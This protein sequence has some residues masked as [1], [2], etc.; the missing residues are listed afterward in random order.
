MVTNIDR[1]HLDY[2]DGIEAILRAFATFANHVP[3]YGVSVMCADDPQVRE[4]LP[5]ITKRTVLYGTSPDAEVRADHIELLPRGSHSTV[6]VG[7]RNLGTL[8]LRVPGR[9]NVLNALAAVAVG[10]ECEVVFSHIAE[11]LA[12]FTGVSRRFEIRGDVSGVTV[13][14]DYGHHPTEILATLAAARG[15]GGRVLVLFQPH[16]FTRTLALAEEFGGA[17]RD[18]DRVWVLDVY[19]AGEAPIAGV[20]GRTIQERAH[21]QGQRQVEHAPDAQAAVEAAAAAAQPGDLILTLGAGDV[22]RLAGDVLR[23]LEER[24]AVGGVR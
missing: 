21:A 22:S 19:P 12:G 23:R 16:R 8:D 4:M 10:L 15:M 2:Y 6:E 11:A 14:D 13:V 9:H 5:R 24:S 18:A 3:F 20:S 1:E 17:F 7:G